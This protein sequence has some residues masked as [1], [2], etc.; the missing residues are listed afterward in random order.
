[1]IFFRS[2]CKHRV[3]LQTQRMI[4]CP[5][6]IYSLLFKYPFLLCGCLGAGEFAALGAVEVL[7]VWYVVC[8]IIV[9]YVWNSGAITSLWYFFRNS[10]AAEKNWGLDPSSATGDVLLSCVAPVAVALPVASLAVGFCA[11]AIMSS[12]D[13]SPA[14]RCCRDL[15][16]PDE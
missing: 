2:I 4:L 12:R 10:S 1:M 8:F 6:P 9:F 14:P 11:Q 3:N 16:L 13:L 5:N 7:L 15:Q